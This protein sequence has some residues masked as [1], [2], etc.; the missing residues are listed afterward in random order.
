MHI[1]RK[2]KNFSHFFHSSMG[3]CLVDDFD[4]S[5]FVSE[6]QSLTGGHNELCVWPFVSRL[7]VTR[8]KHIVGLSSLI[9][10]S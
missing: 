3:S 7:R 2:V 10:W 6:I 4:L 5:L 9:C 1:A 8:Q